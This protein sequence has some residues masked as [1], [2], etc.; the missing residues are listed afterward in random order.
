M[1]FRSQTT[2]V[3]R[4]LGEELVLVNLSTNRMFS[5]NETGA[6]IWDAIVRG[7]DLSD[8]RAQWVESSGAD[9]AGRDFDAFVEMLVHEGL[10]ERA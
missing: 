7:D 5:A 6:F 9:D 8:V 3:S 1:R 10:V 2:T 4:L